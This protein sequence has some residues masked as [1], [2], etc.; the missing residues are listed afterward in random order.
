MQLQ[1]VDLLYAGMPAPAAKKSQM[2]RQ[3]NIKKR[4]DD[5]HRKA[6]TWKVTLQ[7]C[8]NFKNSEI[9]FLPFRHNRIE[10]YNH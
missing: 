2:P 8:L 3:T 7:Q 10:S 6:Y 9:Y 5:V 1:Y 4:K